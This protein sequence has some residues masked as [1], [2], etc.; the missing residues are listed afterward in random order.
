MPVSLQMDTDGKM[1]ETSACSSPFFAIPLKTRSPER[2]CDKTGL[3]SR[4]GCQQ[5]FTVFQEAKGSQGV[6][7][8]PDQELG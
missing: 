4:K 6:N 1:G 8:W 7:C 3:T 5:E 2:R